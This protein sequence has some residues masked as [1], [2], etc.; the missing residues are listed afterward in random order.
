MVASD[1]LTEY[2][3]ALKRNM[4]NIGVDANSRPQVGR[5]GEIRYASS[6]RFSEKIIAQGGPQRD[7]T[8]MAASKAVKRV[9]VENERKSRPLEKLEQSFDSNISAIR[10]IC[11]EIDAIKKTMATRMLQWY[12]VLTIQCMVRQNQARRVVRTK[13]AVRL[14]SLLIFFKSYYRRRLRA[15]SI[16]I[17]TYR[18]YRSRREFVMVMRLHRN[19]KKLQRWYIHCHKRHV[20]L[21]KLTFVR[22]VKQTYD[23]IML[24]G[25]RRAV[26]ANMMIQD[27]D[28]F[29]VRNHPF[30]RFMLSCTR[31]RRVRL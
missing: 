6:R 21:S 9:K 3:C 10:N 8:I 22:I 4:L 15:I 18:Q 14:L 28:Y 27:P 31:R 30:V 16:I 11:D 2:Y 17:R 12:S 13:R 1:I 20:I 25:A 19:A 26:K 24:F 23:H 29:A 7:T 5:G